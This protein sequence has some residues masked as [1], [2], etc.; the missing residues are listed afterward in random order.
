M[1]R[2]IRCLTMMLAS[3]IFLG[4][5]LSACK[6]DK[7]GGG[8]DDLPVQTERPTKVP[9]R[10]LT[11]DTPLGN[12]LAL[13]YD[14]A[15]E[16]QGY[17]TT[18]DRAQFSL[19]NKN[20]SFEIELTAANGK[21]ITSFKNSIGKEYFSNSMDL[22]IIDDKG[23][24]WTDR[25][26]GSPGRQNTYRL[27]YYY[28]EAHILDF[29]VN[30]SENSNEGFDFETELLPLAK[31]WGS[32]DSTVEL[33]SEG[34]KMT[35]T[36]KADPYIYTELSAP[37][38]EDQVN[39]IVIT[40]IANSQSTGANIYY[41]DSEHKG[42][43]ADQM[44][45]FSLHADGQP[46]TYI[47][48]L[49]NLQGDLKGIRFDNGGDA[50]DEY[51]ITSFKAV[52]F[53]SSMDVKIDRTY[54]VFSDKLHQEFRIGAT[55]KIDNIASCGFVWKVP[56]A[57]VDAVQIRDAAGIHN[58]LDFD[59][60][61][62]EYLAFHIKDAGVVGIIIPAE[63]SGTNK[64]TAVLKNGMYEVRQ[65]TD[66]GVTIKAKGFYTVANRLYNDNGSD[67]SAIDTEARLERYPVTDI[68]INGTNSKTKFSGYDTVSGFYY[69][70][71]SGTEFN[72]AYNRNQNKYFYSD[73]TVNNDNE[74]RK[75]YLSFEASAGALECAALLDENMQ[76]MPI[77][78]EVGKN[79][80]GEYEEP[81]YDASDTS[82][83]FSIFPLAL[84]AGQ[85]VRFRE[86]HLYQ[87]WGLNPLKQIS[88]IQFFIGYY[89]LS[90]G[91]TEANCIA[92]Y[93]VYGKDGWTLPDFRGASGVMWTS[94]PQFS[95]IGIH[96]WLSYYTK[97]NIKIQSEYTGSLIRSYGP[98]YADMDYNYISDDGSY[99]FSLRHVEFPQTD[100][101]RTYY[102]ISVEF[103]KDLTI[104]NVREDFTILMMNSRDTSFSK[105]AYLDASGNEQTVAINSS[106]T[107][108]GSYTLPRDHFYYCLYSSGG[109]GNDPMNYSMLLR[110]AKMVIGG[111]EWNGNFHLLYRQTG[112]LD[113]VFLSLDEGK[114]EFKKGDSMVLNVILLPHGGKGDKGIEHTRYVYEDSILNPIRVEAQVGSTVSDDIIPTVSCV[115]NAAEFTVTGS[116]NRNTVVVK[117]FTVLAKPKIFIKGADGSWTQYETS[118]EEFDGYQVALAE[119]GTYTYSFVYSIEN[120]SD[121]LSFRVEVSK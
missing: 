113:N 116:R 35:V 13:A 86:M 103:L 121:S 53:S 9:M 107:S 115:D 49:T 17:F 46:H 71:K 62:V 24:E 40:V 105:L 73:V 44:E 79:F 25:A 76:L 81:F 117:G 66:E 61:T 3:A 22:F 33:V 63:K 99:R 8:P 5:G 58:D 11:G 6:S 54:H 110:D 106:G 60:S 34:V 43:S 65:F 30:R 21:G 90:T 83:G 120:Y 38:P 48:S 88:S 84:N 29:G 70:K 15:N 100:E 39:A 1:K 12:T 82:Y 28:M 64:V 50:G 69:F 96:K 87:N 36:D 31:S 23:T 75:I 20:A 91:V 72:D 109:Q 89:H 68:A 45:S 52:K 10:D 118:Y 114:V 67:F 93:F 97:E 37:I 104:N 4:L 112:S 92:P 108:S 85:T 57:S 80:C 74:N 19:E 59:T 119:D 32:H 2:F 56:E 26:S 111:K 94:Q 42:Y 78:I 95:S 102:T 51:V 7:T 47:V 27:G 77:P 18:G 101:N 16:V 98:T 14:L 41:F 55:Q